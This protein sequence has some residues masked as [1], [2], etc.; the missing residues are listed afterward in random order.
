MPVHRLHHT[1]EYLARLKQVLTYDPETGNCFWLVSRGAAA[2]GKVAGTLQAEG[3]IMIRFER[4]AIL[5]HLFAWY[6]M[7]G[8]WPTLE[9][10]HKN[11]VRHENRWDNLRHGTRSQ[12]HYNRSPAKEGTSRFRGVYAVRKGGGHRWVAALHQK[13]LGY[14]FSEE[15]A[16]KAYDR[17]ALARDAE[18]VRLNFP[19]SDYEP[20][21]APPAEA[22]TGQPEGEA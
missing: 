9:I 2:K 18:F 14:F 7:T 21:P 19:R 5:A 13:Y 12:N 16:A 22:R 3:Y 11:N 6:F 20:L 17:A 1:P 8:E 4:V 15:E 10:D